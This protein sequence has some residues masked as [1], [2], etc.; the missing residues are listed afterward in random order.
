MHTATGAYAD[1]SRA[2]EAVA[3]LLRSGIARDHVR[4]DQDGQGCVVVVATEDAAEAERATRLLAGAGD[5]GPAARDPDVTHAPGLRY[6][7][8][9]DPNP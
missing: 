6:A 1:R 3:G 7:D 2:D 4:V 8:Q 9:N 5:P